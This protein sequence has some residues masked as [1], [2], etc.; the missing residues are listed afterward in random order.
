MI[1]FS[2]ACALVGRALAGSARQQLVADLARSRP[3]GKALARLR[4]HMRVNSFEPF[5]SAFDH[6]TRQEGFHVLHDWDGKA[7]RVS[8]QIIP[9]DVLDYLARH[10]GDQPS[11]AAALAVLLDYYY[12][13]VLQLLALRIWDD[14]DA[15]AN[16]DQLVEL[17]AQLQGAGGSGQPFVT[18]AA[19]LILVATS[20][21]EEVERGYDRLLRRVKTLND[22][23]Q[24]NVA[25]GHAS[26]MGCHLRF[27]FE[28]TYGRDTLQMRD[29]N[30]A[31]YPWLCFALATL[32]R[33]YTR[34]R[35]RGIDV[36]GRAAIV[37]SMV[38]GLSPDARAFLGAAPRS[39]SAC[40]ADR[41]DFRDRFFSSRGDLVD[42]FERHRPVEGVYS[43]LSF[44]FN[45]SHNVVK[46]TIVDAVLRGQPWKVAFNDLLAGETVRLKPDTANG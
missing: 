23:H 26:S 5:L 3:F 8:E 44:F 17:L 27:G 36:E 34:L 28:A 42:E 25:A 15:D 46:G 21:F 2:T 33:E 16:L 40:E 22:A 24:V 4:D 7:D 18:D 11:D 38:N 14:G 19:T 41:A 30:V 9:V 37:E 29:D 1:S 35:E 45:F 39:L 43:P 32:M 31:D 6:R 20:H 13:H 10:R 12:F